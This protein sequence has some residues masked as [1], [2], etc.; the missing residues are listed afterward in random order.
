MKT[1]ICCKCK[2]KKSL[3][4]FNKNKSNKDGLSYECKACAK[5]WRDENKS[6]R[7]EWKSVHKDKLAKYRN[8][9]DIRNPEKKKQIM[10]KYRQKNKGKFR[11]RKRLSNR[12]RSALKN[13]SKS[14]N[15][16]NLIGCSIIDLKKHLQ[17]TA[18]KNKYADF[19][20]NNYSGNEYHIDHI[21]PCDAFNL[22]CSYHQKLCFNWT[23]LQILDATS[24]IRKKN[25]RE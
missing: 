21:M 5:L 11:L 22:E 13:N 7:N 12:I 19:D 16:L 25:K 14:T 15:T 4:A 23:N 17:D 1:K 3:L 6:F 2:T 10:R 8:E 20:I 24:N 9:Y 18:I